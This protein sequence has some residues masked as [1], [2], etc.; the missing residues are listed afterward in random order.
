MEHI[1]I[2]AIRH[3]IEIHAVFIY[4]AIFLGV[5]IE[6]EIAVI[7]AGIFAFLG[8]INIFVAF[9]SVILGGAMKSLIGYSIGYYLNKHHS[10]RPFMGKIEK[11]ISHFLPRFIER[12]FWSIFTSRFL[13][14]GIGWFTLL[15]SGYKNIVLKT[16]IKAES[17]SLV[18]W[19]ILVMS[20]G[21]FFGY[22]ALSISRDVRHVLVLILVF[23]I[24]FFILEKV[25]AFIFELF[26]INQI[27][28]EEKTN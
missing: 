3:F 10:H 8:S 7:F 16:Y 25:I 27:K 24:G 6:G 18:I 22:T 2:S 23:F 14:L 28:I 15:F 19:S 13:I 4:I 5:I 21:Y 17:F 1:S 20:L 12:P 9:A 26:N 11:R